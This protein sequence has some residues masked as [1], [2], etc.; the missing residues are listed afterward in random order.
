VRQEQDRL[1][2]EH[3]TV[4]RVGDFFFSRGS[5]IRGS[6]H[7]L[8]VRM[9]P[10]LALDLQSTAGSVRINDLRG[11]ITASVQ[12]GSTVIEGFRGPLRLSSQA[13]SIRATGVPVA[14]DSRITCM[15]GSVRLHLGRGSD[16]RVR[17][18]AQMGRVRIEGARRSESTGIGSSTEELVLGEGRAS[19]EIDASMGSIRVETE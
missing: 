8:V 12:A 19:L 10:A 4:G 13:G 2:I 17:A 7:R 15:A 1:V 11:P 18:R 16:V 6:H 3:S 14:G 5:D 9:N